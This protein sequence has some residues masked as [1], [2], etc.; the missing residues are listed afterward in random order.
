MRIEADII[1]KSPGT[2]RA[3]VEERLSWE[4]STKDNQAV[5]FWEIQ[6]HFVGADME[7]KEDYLRPYLYVERTGKGVKLPGNIH[8][9]VY[10][11]SQDSLISFWEEYGP[12][13]Q[14]N[15]IPVAQIMNAVDFFRLMVD[16]WSS[17]LKK[18]APTICDLINSPTTP[19]EDFVSFFRN[20][21]RDNRLYVIG[22]QPTRF[23]YGHVVHDAG[24][25][26]L[27]LPESLP[28]SDFIEC[29]RKIIQSNLKRYLKTL[30][31]FM[32]AD[33]FHRRIIIKPPNIMVAALFT[34]WYSTQK[35]TFDPVEYQRQ[36]RESGKAVKD[37]VLAKYRTWKNR[38]KISQD[39]YDRLKAYI[40]KYIP[41]ETDKDEIERKV[42][43]YFKR[44]ITG[45]K[46]V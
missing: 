44:Y 30:R 42:E 18:D 11:L 37:Q 45:K 24:L 20:D 14:G 5:A 28:K 29:G 26:F 16:L 19:V 43:A 6:S 4:V 27:Q 39:A 21:A 25:Y 41:K 9:E 12:L 7:P 15:I 22:G 23:S 10:N 33:V 34:F 32:E 40:D 3:W 17:I 46:E 38:R 31:N 1:L 2:Y 35:K 36:R 8:E 13:I